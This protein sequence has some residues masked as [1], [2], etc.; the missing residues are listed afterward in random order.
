MK[1]GVLKFES[2][3]INELKIRIYGDTAVGFGLTTE[4]VSCKGEDVSGQNRFTDTFIK[5]DGRRQCVATHAGKV[6]P[7]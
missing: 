3:V 1:S 4:K 7:T 5:R 6:M 2:F